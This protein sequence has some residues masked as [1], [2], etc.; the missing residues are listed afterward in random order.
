M[1]TADSGFQVKDLGRMSYVD[2]LKVQED[3]FQAMLD[4]KRTGGIL[5]DSTL[6]LVEHTPVYTLGKSG[7]LN[8]LRRKPEDV[9]A[10]FY[11][12]T[13]GGDITYHG[14]GQI[15]GYPIFDLERFDMGV[16]KYIWSIEEAIIQTIAKHDIS[17][18]RIKE[19]SGVWLDT[20]T[21]TARKICAIGVKA[22]RYVTMHG[23]AFNVNTDLS[24]F[25]HIIPCGIDDKGVTSLEKELGRKQDFEALKQDV[26]EAFKTL[27]PATT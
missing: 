16:A 27:F 11:K 19:A 20:E 6:L 2:A 4:A 1:T 12:T 3:H 22:S 17:G 18:G 25:D 26:V 9:G 21:D 5:P 23:F 10:E 7:D 13:R 15:V 24:Y 8:N 14:P